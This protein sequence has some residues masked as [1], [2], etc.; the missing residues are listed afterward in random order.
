MGRRAALKDFKLKA[1]IRFTF[2]KEY[3]G[4]RIEEHG[5][6]AGRPERRDCSD[7]GE[8]SEDLNWDGGRETDDRD[9]NETDLRWVTDLGVKECGKGQG[10]SQVCKTHHG[11]CHSSLKLME[12][13]EGSGDL[14]AFSTGFSR[15]P[16]RAHLLKYKEK[17]TEET[18]SQRQI[19]PVPHSRHQ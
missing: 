11:D 9:I 17:P 4:C 18:L 3:F 7:P 8:G 2:W 6:G 5:S 15:N 14:W 12:G 1:G 19:A 13:R 16:E 10:N